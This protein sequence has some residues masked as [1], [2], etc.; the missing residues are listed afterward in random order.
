[1]RYLWQESW[2][3]AWG[4][5]IALGFYDIFL[6]MNDCIFCKIVKGEIPAYKIYENEK[7]LA[8]LDIM[9]SCEGHT[10][11]IPKKHVQ[12]V[13]DYDDLGEYFEVV[14]K[15]AKHF[16]EVTGKE[17]IR[18]MIFGWEVPHAHI[19]LK[20]GIESDW[21][22]KKVSGERLKMVQLKYRLK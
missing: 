13:W 11:V 14:G 3:F 12:W 2:E 8:F 22:N 4:Y 17:V 6:S 20:P 10:L 18:S 16:R 5:Y 15:I 19:H 9:P 7:F 21:G 1:M